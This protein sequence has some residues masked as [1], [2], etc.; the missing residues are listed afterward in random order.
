MV[1][2]PEVSGFYRTGEKQT[3]DTVFVCMECNSKRTVRV[4]K[5]IPQCSKCKKHTYWY[6]VTEL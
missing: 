1:L 5:T 4:G 2:L 3:K 6:K